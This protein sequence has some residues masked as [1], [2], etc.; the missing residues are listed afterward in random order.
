MA[1]YEISEQ[2]TRADAG[3]LELVFDTSGAA[4]L[5]QVSAN[6]ADRRSAFWMNENSP[7][8]LAADPPGKAGEPRFDVSFSVDG[9]KRLLVS[10]RDLQTGKIIYR[11]YPVIKLT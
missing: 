2:R 8:F 3:A 6:D 1:I 9:N 7:T 4:R 5:S 10:A 11:D